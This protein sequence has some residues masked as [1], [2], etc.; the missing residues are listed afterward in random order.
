MVPSSFLCL[1]FCMIKIEKKKSPKL[2][3]FRGSLHSVIFSSLITHKTKSNSNQ[4][5]IYIYIYPFPICLL[6]ETD[7]WK[8]SL[9]PGD[10]SLRARFKYGP[11]RKALYSHWVFKC[12]GS[13]RDPKLL[14]PCN[15]PRPFCPT[16][17][18]SR[19][20]PASPLITVMGFRG[21]VQNC[22]STGEKASRLLSS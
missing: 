20:E 7:R 12:R 21:S 9:R 8:K 11:L 22:S 3:I 17:S 13:Q 10:Q 1:K 18:L 19:R 4:A 5:L 14:D 6:L 2:W 15:P 16:H